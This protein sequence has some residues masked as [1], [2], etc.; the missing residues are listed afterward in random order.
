MKATI[1]KTS[2]KFAANL[3]QLK[4]ESAT[5]IKRSFDSITT[6][7]DFLIETKENER[8][9]HYTLLNGK[10]DSVEQ[11]LSG[12][13]DSL[14]TRVAKL[15]REYDKLKSS[16]EHLSKERDIYKTL[17]EF[18]IDVI[19]ERDLRSVLKRV[20]QT[21]TEILV[22]DYVSLQIMGD[23]GEIIFKYDSSSKNGSNHKR[24]FIRHIAEAVISTGDP[25]RID[26]DDGAGN[27]ACV[28]LKTG[29]DT[30]G[31]LYSVRY[32]TSFTEFDLELLRTITD[33]IAISVESERL[34]CALEDY[35]ETL[36][37]DLR[38]KYDFDEIKGTSPQVTKVLATVA[39]VAETESAV[40][41][42]GESGTG[43]E[44]L[45]RALHNNSSRK[46]HPFV[47]IN[48]AAI[49][50]TL[51]ESELFGYEK[52][53]FT[54]AV[55][56]KPGKFEIADKG[57]IFL[58]EIGELSPLL[59]VKL[60]RFLQSHEFEPLGST[61]LKRADVRIISATKKDLM[62]TV[63]DGEFRDD[64]YYRINVIDIKLP[65]LYKRQGDVETLAYHFLR[66]YAGKND[67]Q[68]SSI[69]ETALSYLRSYRYP[70][71][72]RELENII[73]RAV[74]LCKGNILTP[75]ELPDTVKRTD[76]KYERIPGTL[77]ELDDYKKE[78]WEKTIVPLERG[79]ASKLLESSGGNISA[80]ARLGGMHRKQLQRILNRANLKET[81]ETERGMKD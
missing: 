2:E 43:K 1:G 42:E 67:K 30:L 7:K 14:N 81:S 8:T 22:C 64:L 48:C 41:I 35:R 75:N 5:Q 15:I 66:E 13:E 12:F 78:L 32:E 18:S 69:S 44:L 24:R 51:L 25:V 9:K 56:R 57:T 77:K 21:T 58:D 34:F 26:T 45:A 10:I 60:L 76:L 61:I 71:N 6:L 74:V 33:K 27:I 19:S 31:V 68:I 28:P 49:P 55:G 37:E 54:G 62:K 73:E 63:E 11:K 70:G 50:E 40:L 39:D 72:V 36:I 29:E 59:Q 3:K 65:P 52:G 20:V 46:D 16:L 4:K 17:Y 38:D 53:A 79:F 47:A 23:D 80:A